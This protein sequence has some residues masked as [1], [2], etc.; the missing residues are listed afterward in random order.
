MLSV[1]V[2]CSRVS[3]TGKCPHCKAISIIK[4]GRTKTGKQ[5]YYCKSCSRRCIDYYSYKACNPAVNLQIIELT[6]EGLGIR[7]TARV[8]KISPTTLIRKIIQIADN[9]KPPIICKG[10]TYEV[11]EIKTYWKKKGKAVW[12][13]YALERKTK[14]VVSFN[15]GGRSN[16]TLKVIVDTLMMSEAKS[17]YTDRFP[18]YQ[19]IID[20]KKHKVCFYGTN[21]IERK[22]LTLRTHLKRLHRRTICFSRSIKMLFACLKL[23]FFS[24]VDI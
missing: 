15:V 18:N 16:R 21:H 20:K 11:D 10:R 12:I 6:R 14:Q 2:S 3:D 5:Q 9:L 1:A 8:L 13:V 7:S 23:Y 19:Y 17:I 24:A 22:N 4:N